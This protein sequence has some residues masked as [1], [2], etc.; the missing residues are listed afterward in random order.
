VI[1]R[2]ADV[3]PDGTDVDLP[4]DL[5][6]LISEADETIRVETVVLK[7][8]VLPARNG[9]SF[10]GRLAGRAL[11]PCSRCLKPCALEVD[12]LFNLFY[13]FAPTDGREVQ[14]PDDAL[15]Y[16]FLREGDGIDLEQVATEQMYLEIPMKLLCRATCRGLCA[17]CGADL[18]TDGCRCVGV[19]SIS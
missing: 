11:V 15:D 3:T 17:R 10:R 16:A 8:R 12:R 6:P 14:I 18:N 9:L 1:I 5:D 4:L 2:P 19:Q 13:A 7:G